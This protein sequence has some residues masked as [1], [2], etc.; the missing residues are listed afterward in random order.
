VAWKEW[1]KKIALKREAKLRPDDSRAYMGSIHQ[2]VLVDSSQSLRQ[3]PPLPATYQHQ[4]P[5]SLKRPSAVVD[6]TNDSDDEWPPAK[7]LKPEPMDF[8]ER[9]IQLEQQK[10]QKAKAAIEENIELSEEQEKVLKMA[11]RGD[12]I[13]VSLSFSAGSIPMF[14]HR[15][16][17]A[18]Q[19][20]HLIG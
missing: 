15:K 14:F 20:L 9:L 11:L 19:P 8:R 12:N 17:S 13:F 5:P 16:L 4:Q 2:P 18:S 7:R 10:A 6:L 3:Q 1:L